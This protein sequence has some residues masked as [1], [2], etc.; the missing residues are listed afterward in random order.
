MRWSCTFKALNGISVLIFASLTIL[1]SLAHSQIYKQENLYFN[2]NDISLKLE[3]LNQAANDTV[4]LPSKVMRRS[5]ILP[6]WGQ[7]TNKQAWKIPII[8]GLI[9]GLGYYSYWSHTQY[10][11]YRAAY[12]NSF[13][14]NT[15]FRFGQTP[16]WIDQNASPQFLRDNRNFYRNRRDFIFIT[17]GLAYI[18]NVIDAYVYAHMRDFD[19]SDDLG[20]LN[21]NN[22]LLLAG[23]PQITFTYKIRF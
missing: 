21:I 17:I 20:T 16:S 3:S 6:G 10:E 7:Y 9:G 11:G 4:P 13:P 15:D 5:L 8:Y 2:S 14:T 12:Y 19:V 18:L 1:S 22:D 23:H